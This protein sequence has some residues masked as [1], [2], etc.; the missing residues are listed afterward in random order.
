MV[1]QLL[2]GPLAMA[3]LK[4]MLDITKRKAIKP[5]KT[6]FTKYVSESADLA[7]GP[8]TERIDSAK[9]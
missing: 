7:R 5:D 1:T 3:S 8:H 9:Q 4:Y 2:R 6:L